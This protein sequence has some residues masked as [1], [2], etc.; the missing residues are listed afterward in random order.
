VDFHN[1]V[2]I[3]QQG[4]VDTLGKTEATTRCGS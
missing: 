4:D 2:E 3:T 1:S